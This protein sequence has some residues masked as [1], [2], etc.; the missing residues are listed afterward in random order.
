[1]P[2]NNGNLRR[3]EREPEELEE[4][5]EIPERPE[6]PETED[7]VIVLRTNFPIVDFR[8]NNTDGNEARFIKINQIV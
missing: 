8:K 3:E 6:I 2:E 5:E 4:G 7:S 1:M